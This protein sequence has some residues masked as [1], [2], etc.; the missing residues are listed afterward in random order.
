MTPINNDVGIVG[1]DLEANCNNKVA[2]NMSDL[3]DISTKSRM[4]LIQG[5]E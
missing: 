2:K 1:A 3:I 5:R 4:A